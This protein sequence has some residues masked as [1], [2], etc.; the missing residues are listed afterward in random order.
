[1]TGDCHVR[2]R[3]SLKV[4]ILRATRLDN[5]FLKRLQANP[6]DLEALSYFQHVRDLEWLLKIQE[7]RKKAPPDVWHEYDAVLR[8]IQVGVTANPNDPH[9]TTAV[10]YS[11]KGRLN[12]VY[13]EY[14]MPLT[15]ATYRPKGVPLK[16]T[17]Y[18]AADGTTS[19][20]L[21]D[22]LEDAKIEAEVLSTDLIVNLYMVTDESDPELKGIFD[23]RGHLIQIK[24]QGRAYLPETPV[25]K[26]RHRIGQ[27]N[28]FTDESLRDS[29]KQR[30]HDQFV[31]GHNKIPFARSIIAGRRGISFVSRDIFA[32]DYVEDGDIVTAINLFQNFG[33]ES[34][35]RAVRTLGKKM[36]EGSYV[37]FGKVS[38]F[39]NYK[40][41][42][43]W[44][45]RNGSLVRIQGD[46]LKSLLSDAFL[47]DEAQIADADMAKK[48]GIDFTRDRMIFYIQNAG[49]GVHFKF[50]PAM[51]Q[52]LQNASGLTAVI[53]DIRPMTTTVPVFL[54]LG[55]EISGEKLNMR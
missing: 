1:M 48:G 16:V 37:V 53:I 3:E 33:D 30:L 41:V 13:Q 47:V 9:S 36:K 8:N 43:V 31:N 38:E 46:Y 35:I 42:S 50:D 4:R 19:L 2:F 29:I 23:D 18:A 32:D 28:T 12:K 6:Q 26:I 49:Q 34:T 25:S 11:E 52:Q 39:H 14:V 15:A 55:N 5:Y 51:I 7:L 44:Q 45:K 40:E 20:D 22:M 10:G 54:G 24:Y 21:L 27:L 17:Q